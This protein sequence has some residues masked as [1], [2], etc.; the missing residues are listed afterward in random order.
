MLKKGFLTS[1]SSYT[2]YAYS[3]DI[4]DLY[5]EATDEVFSR[6]GA[7]L[8]GGSDIVKMLEGPVKHAGFRRLT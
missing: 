7:S 8:K 3:S 6:I 1:N 2:T 5:L 4:I